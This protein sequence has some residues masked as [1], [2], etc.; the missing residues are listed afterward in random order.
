MIDISRIFTKL[1]DRNMEI[2][3]S[4]L[5][6]NLVVLAFGPSHSYLEHFKSINIGCILPFT[7]VGFKVKIIVW[8][9]IDHF[10]TILPIDWRLND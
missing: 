10:R 5:I 1:I 3:S 8:S 4:W 9:D 6:F 2:S 7:I